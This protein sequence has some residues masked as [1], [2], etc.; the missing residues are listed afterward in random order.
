MFILLSIMISTSI[1]ALLY[2]Y[3]QNKQNSFK[4]KYEL[5]SDLRQL[6]NYCRQHRSASHMALLFDTADNEQIGALESKI[7]ILTQQIVDKASFDNKA[8]YRILQT[9]MNHI[10][11]EWRSMTIGKNQM[12]HGKAIRHS[13]FL[14]DEIMLMWLLDQEKQ[15]LDDVYNENWQLTIDS[16]ELLT[17]FRVII[18]NIDNENGQ[19]RIRAQA[20]TLNRKLN[21]LSVLSPVVYGSPFCIR[22]R[23]QLMQLVNDEEFNYSQVQLYKISSDVSLVIF[24]AYDQ[25]LE[26]VAETIYQPFPKLAKTI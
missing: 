10:E 8:T 19:A 20:A 15:N 14:I 3:G 12:V 17:S 1:L 16:L 18:Q 25:V 9:R 13:L 11:S 22:A 23:E 6:I 5:V 24:Y 26:K 21:Q 4:E 2:L 7:S